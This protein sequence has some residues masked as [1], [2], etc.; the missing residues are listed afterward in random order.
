MSTDQQLQKIARLERLQAL[1]N[2]ALGLGLFFLFSVITAAGFGSFD[3]PKNWSSIYSALARDGLLQWAVV[4]L[5]VLGISLI[6]SGICMQIVI[7]RDKQ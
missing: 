4:P 5:I 3:N 2:W 6:A 7:A 1:R